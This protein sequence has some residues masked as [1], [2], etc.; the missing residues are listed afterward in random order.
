MSDQTDPQTDDQPS[1]LRGVTNW[2]SGIAAAIAEGAAATEPTAQAAAKSAAE[3]ASQPLSRAVKSAGPDLIEGLAMPFGFDVDGESFTADTDFCFDWFGKSGRPFLYDHGLD[4]KLQAQVIGRQTDYEARDEGIWA[5]V[6]LDRN[7]RYRKAVDSLIER[8][9]LGFSSGAMPH[10]ATKSA[11]GHI[12][13]WPWVELTG[14][15]IPA[16]PGA[17][18]LHYVKSADAIRHLEAV[19]IQIPDPL[20]AALAA[21]DEWGDSRDAAPVS[22]RLAA[23]LDRVSVEMDGLRSHVREYTD[24][25]VKAGR[26]LSAST[27]ERLTRYLAVVSELVPDLQA[28]L[29]EADAEK[30]GKSSDLFAAWLTTE[31]RLARYDRIP[32][33]QGDPS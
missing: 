18:N 8:N 24:M 17:L 5:M 6:Q 32:I 4:D 31:E 25:R 7:V 26:V 22:E 33:K 14:T 27:R 15:P 3:A 11:S 10:L 2:G 23:R 29:E 19:D 16:H 12:T 1:P 28:L 20:K 30:A 13:R 21:L 9:A